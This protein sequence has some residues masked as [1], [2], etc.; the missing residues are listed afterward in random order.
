MVKCRDD[1]FSKPVQIFNDLDDYCENLKNE[2]KYIE[3]INEKHFNY[4]I[5]MKTFDKEKFDNTTHCEY[6]NYKFDKDYNDRKIELYERVD[7]NKL[8]YIIDNC[9]FNEETE[10]TLNLYYESLN[11][12]GQKKVI[13]NQSK[14][15]KNRYYGGICLTSIKRKVR[16]SFMSDNIFDIY[17]E[18]SHPRILLYLC[19]KHDIDC[20]NLIEYINNRKYFLNEIS[21]NRK[22]SKTLILQMLNGGFKINTVIMKKLINF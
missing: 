8:K 16:N 7:K 22:E 19:K 17:M 6:C 21:N 3:K 14:D 11:K 12:K 1:K 9:R 4:K 15:D 2:L 20:K 5:D 10:N 13:Y 18:N